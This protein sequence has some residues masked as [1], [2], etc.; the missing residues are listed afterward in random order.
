MWSPPLQSKSPSI[1]AVRVT[2]GCLIFVELLC[3][4]GSPSRSGNGLSKSLFQSKALSI[5]AARSIVRTQHRTQPP[6]SARKPS[7]RWQERSSHCFDRKV[8]RSKCEPEPLQSG[9]RMARTERQ[10][11]IQSGHARILLYGLL[12]EPTGKPWNKP[13]SFRV[14]RLRVAL[15][16]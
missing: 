15:R 16:L 5:E 3:S 7:G 10:S 11:A 9:R 2:A 1:N 12:F 6:L 4:A 8:S 14:S 13:F